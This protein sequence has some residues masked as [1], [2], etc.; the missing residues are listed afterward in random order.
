MFFY[1]D[2]YESNPLSKNNITKLYKFKTLATIFNPLLEVLIKFLWG[3]EG[4]YKMVV[5]WGIIISYIWFRF[6]ICINTFKITHNSFKFN[7]LPTPFQAF[8]LPLFHY[9]LIIVAL[10]I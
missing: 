6:I 7:N 5:I 4:Y 2:S 3:I 10:Q 8:R 1:K 9:L